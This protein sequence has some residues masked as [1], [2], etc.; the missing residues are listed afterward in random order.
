MHATN[1]HGTAIHGLHDTYHSGLCN[2]F[3]G[4]L[5]VSDLHRGRFDLR[6]SFRAS[7]IICA[8]VS[9]D[10]RVIFHFGAN[11]VSLDRFDTLHWNYMCK[12]QKITYGCQWL[13]WH[14]FISLNYQQR[15]IGVIVYF[16]IRSLDIEEAQIL[17][18]GDNPPILPTREVSTVSG[19]VVRLE[20]EPENDIGLVQATRHHSDIHFSVLTFVDLFIDHSLQCLWAKNT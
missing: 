6:R 7:E 15:E 18:L 11:S 1:S 14:Q 19:L 13:T 3:D 17:I 5:V 2:I 8:H 16:G 4:A 10:C 12:Y 20:N 9:L